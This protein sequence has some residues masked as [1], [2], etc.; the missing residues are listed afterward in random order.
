MPRLEHVHLINAAGFGEVKIPVGGH[1]RLFSPGNGDGKTTL[2]RA[3]LFFYL[4][5]NEKASYALD[6]NKKDFV[7]S[8]KPRGCG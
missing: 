6:E 3:V 5:N 8:A 1:C 2:L 4:G 7:S